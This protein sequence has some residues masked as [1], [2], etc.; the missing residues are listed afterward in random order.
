LTK[1]T[2]LLFGDSHS[3]AIQ[4]AIEKRQGK[5][6]PVPVTAYRL[7]KIKNG[8]QQGDTSFEDFLDMIRSLRDEDMVFSMIGGNQHAVFSTI[9]HPKRFD[10]FVSGRE[11]RP[12]KGTEI[13]PY[14]TL[15]GVFEKGIRNSD[16]K[17]LEALRKATSARVIHII[18]P[19]PKKDNAFIQQY[20]ETH[21]A[22]EDIGSLGV[23][24]P[25]LRLKFWA[26]QT[27]QLQ[28]VCA[29]LGIE[30]MLPP[31]TALDDKGFLAT[32]YYA[33]D[34]THANYG[35]GELVLREIENLYLSQ[36]A[37]AQARS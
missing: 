14:R 15:E 33:N 1:Q 28:K 19:P 18:P 20:H 25:G 21:F 2:A 36:P 8:K 16:G 11:P 5:R 37:Q 35:Y 30:V 3:Y 17:S 13:I 10:F 12:E 31:A 27:R 7:A 32:D 6:R 34:A 22:K 29:E 23:S 24:S 26:L 9:Q 4:R